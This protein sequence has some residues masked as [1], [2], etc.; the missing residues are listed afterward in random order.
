MLPSVSQFKVRAG[1][2]KV[3]I[4]AIPS[5]LYSSYIHSIGMLYPTG[6][7]NWMRGSTIKALASR[8]IKWEEATTTNI[9][10]DMGMFNNKVTLTAD[11]F[12]KETVDIL[13]GIPTS[14]SMGLGLSGGADG[15]NRIANA[16]TAINKGVELMLGYMNYEGT[17]K[18]GISGN[19]TYVNNEVTSLGSSKEPLIGPSYNGQAAITRTDIGHPIG[20]Y[21]GYQVDKVYAS[22]A[23]IDADNA[24]ARAATGDEDAYYQ[25]D[26]TCSG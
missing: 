4:D 22:Q 8:D 1:W 12:T 16:A 17:F 15:G 3:G 21:Y 14:P 24:A 9:G 13:V 2:G 6:A 19:F 26:L 10:I 23:E 7:G 11:Y 20:S 5:F 25:S 18:Y